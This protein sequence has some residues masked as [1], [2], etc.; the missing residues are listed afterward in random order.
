MILGM[1]DSYAYRKTNN[2]ILSVLHFAKS[3]DS[4]TCGRRLAQLAVLADA[5]DGLEIV[6]AEHCVVVGVQRWAL[7][8]RHCGSCSI[9]GSACQLMF[10]QSY[11][12]VRVQ[13]YRDSLDGP[14]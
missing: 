6:G 12:G 2:G 9:Q 3:H 4:C 7:P 14:R 5:R 11:I 1:G 8:G 10:L 13:A